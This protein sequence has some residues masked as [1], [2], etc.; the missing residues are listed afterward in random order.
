MSLLL[1]GGSS[2]PAA[3]PFTSNALQTPARTPQRGFAD[4]AQNLLLTTL[5]VVA[6]AA[7][8]TP[9]V[10]SNPAAAQ[11]RQDTAVARNVAALGSAPFK[12]PTWAQTTTQSRPD[13]N[14]QYNLSLYAPV[15]AAAP[16]T[17]YGFSNPSALAARQS[18]QAQQQ[19]PWLFQTVQPPFAALAV[20]PTTLRANPDTLVS[21]SNLAVLLT[22]RPVQAP[23][24]DVL[25]AQRS[26]APDVAPN[27]LTT[28]LVPPAVAPF[29][30]VSF[31]NARALVRTTVFDAVN[32]LNT[33]LAQVAAPF[34][35]PVFANPSAQQR[36]QTQPAVQSALLAQAPFTPP[37]WPQPAAL[38]RT[39]LAQA[40]Q[41][42][43]YGAQPFINA[44]QAQPRGLAWSPE[45]RTWVQSG[46]IE[47]VTAPF[48]QVSFANPVA[49]QWPPELRTW[50]QSGQLEEA[51]ALPFSLQNW[52]TPFTAQRAQDTAQYSA[53]TFITQDGHHGWTGQLGSTSWVAEYYRDQDRIKFSRQEEDEIV[54]LLEAFLKTRKYT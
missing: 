23:L 43:L 51:T 46:Q 52:P 37:V 42:A 22:Q 26:V 40:V 2:P 13:F 16:F 29:V 24:S 8:F 50:V 44:P 28:T 47:E 19:A 41:N 31:D 30:P 53:L 3:A 20:N 45:L 14:P 5:A 12:T 4:F 27:L 7:P 49:S 11:F 35:P 39:Q 21:G 32:L 25:R 33:T 34:T 10:F 6:A 48:T 9:Y 1:A 15:V 36:L 54:V 38:A 17:P 18:A